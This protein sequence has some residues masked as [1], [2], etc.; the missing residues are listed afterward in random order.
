[1]TRPLGGPNTDPH[2]V[3]G[4]FWK[5]RVTWCG[6]YPPSPH[7]I[8]SFHSVR[9][10]KKNTNATGKAKVLQASWLSGGELLNFRAGKFF[11]KNLIDGSEIWLTLVDMDNFTILGRLI[12]VS[13]TIV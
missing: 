10:L 1:M 8:E 4:G 5:T 3:F 12:V 11:P 9:P 2:K 13:I 6:N 7:P